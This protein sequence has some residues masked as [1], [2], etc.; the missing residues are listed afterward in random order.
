MEITGSPQ[1][2]FCSSLPLGSPFGAPQGQLFNWHSTSERKGNLKNNSLFDQ[3]VLAL[4][5]HLSSPGAPREAMGKQSSGILHRLSERGR[6]ESLL[7]S[8]SFHKSNINT[9]RKAIIL[10]IDAH[11]FKLQM[12]CSDFHLL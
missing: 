12:L 9:F 2:G 5:H 7:K 10:G 1:S 8:P 6:H 4:L 3:E 11:F